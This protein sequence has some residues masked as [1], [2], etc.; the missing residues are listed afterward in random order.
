MHAKLQP[1]ASSRSALMFGVVLLAAIGAL[2]STVMADQDDDAER[3]P[4]NAGDIYSPIERT[5]APQAP[6]PG[7]PR[8]LVPGTSLPADNGPVLF[9]DLKERLRFADP[10]FRDMKLAL[11]LR[12]H[13]FDRDNASGPRSRAWAGGSALAIKTGFLD[14]WLQF[15]AAGAT[16]QPLFAPDGEG[17]T[18]LLT[19]TG[20]GQLVCHRQC[21]HA[22]YGPRG[23]ARPAARQDA[24]HQ[25]AGQPH[26]AQR[27]RGRG[28]HTAPRR[29]QDTRLRHWLFV[30]LQGARQLAL[31][32]VLGGAWR[33]GR[34]RR[35][36]GWRQGGPDR[37]TDIG[38][39]RLLDRRRPQHDVCGSRLDH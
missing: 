34:S 4:S 6:L 12:T 19:Q 27:R 1:R 18:L 39:H 11:Y 37:R 29:G 31:R 14:D 30:G 2:G 7:G 5:F 24:V 26:A 33:N 9:Q 10:F 3:V 21:A 22:I 20:G 36:G 13:D 25:S 28:D 8:R 16:S 32:A 35:V 23:C 17:G 15:E 38:C